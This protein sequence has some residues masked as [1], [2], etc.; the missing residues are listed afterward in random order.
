M[1]KHVCAENIFACRGLDL[2]PVKIYSSFSLY[3]SLF[4]K[5]K[6]IFSLK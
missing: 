4:K 5:I 1:V 3:L 2:K 6:V